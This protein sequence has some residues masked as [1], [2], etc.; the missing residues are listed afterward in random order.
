MFGRDKV[1]FTYARST[2][3]TKE[4]EARALVDPIPCVPADAGKLSTETIPRNSQPSVCVDVRAAHSYEANRRPYRDRFNQ[5]RRA[6]KK[7]IRMNERER[8]KVRIARRKMSTGGS[9]RMESMHDAYFISRKGRK[10]ISRL[11]ISTNQSL[12]PESNFGLDRQCWGK[13]KTK[14]AESFGNVECRDLSRPPKSIFGGRRR[15]ASGGGCLPFLPI[16]WIVIL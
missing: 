2:R 16:V 7:R 3:R 9:G 5:R 15:L 12:I 11:D 8:E 6:A 1:Y 13:F 10:R 4:S 14:R